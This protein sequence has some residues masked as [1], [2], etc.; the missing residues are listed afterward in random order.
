MQLS[1]SDLSSAQ[2]TVYEPMSAVVRPTASLLPAEEP[3]S[4][5]ERP[6]AWRPKKRSK[7]GK[8]K[9]IESRCKHTKFENAQQNFEE[10]TLED[11]LLSVDTS[12]QIKI[13]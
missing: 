8:Q 3:S 5:D 10:Q 13:Q 9:Y 1:V 6:T 12:R 4:V 2:Q 7:D 11:V